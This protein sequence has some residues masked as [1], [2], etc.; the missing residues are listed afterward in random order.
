VHRAHPRA[1]LVGA[2]PSAGRPRWP[3]QPRAPLR[4]SLQ[5]FPRQALHARALAFAHPLD[6]RP[7]EFESPL[8]A[9]IVALLEVL[10]QDVAA[11][12]E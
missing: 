11:A 5:G 4:Q 3:P 8:P 6:D 1:P 9:D 12:G 7:L 10:R 2:R